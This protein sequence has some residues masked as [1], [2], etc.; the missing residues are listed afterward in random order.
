MWVSWCRQARRRHAG[1]ATSSGAAPGASKRRTARL[2]SPA[3]P[4]LER[5]FG[6]QVTAA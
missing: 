4:I 3:A 2:S 6:P 1:Y 5:K